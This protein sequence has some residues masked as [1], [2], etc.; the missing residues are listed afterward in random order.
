M[1]N[2]PLEYSYLIINILA[3][4]IPLVLSFDKK[5]AFFK[6]W[7]HLWSAILIPAIL[8]IV[9]DIFFT[10]KGVW[11]FNKTYLT[12]INVANLPLEEVLFFFT[13]PYACVFTYE[14]I[15]VYFPEYVPPNKL[16]RYGTII[17]IL[18]LVVAVLLNP[19]RIYTDITFLLLA[20]ML[21]FLLLKKEYYVFR[22]FYPAY[23]II[24]FPFLFVNGA[25]TGSGFAEPIVWYNNTENL[26]M[27][28]ATIPV[29][30][31]FYGMLLIISNVYIF[32]RNQRSIK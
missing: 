20:G 4:F 17:I 18:A 7:K 24:L 9:W 26:G 32:E 30:D 27:R 28:I 19:W 29:E 8:F 22:H 10:A 16:I 12:G 1:S 14:V 11:G 5:V 13:I 6:K 23:A 21:I 15:K 3:V 25:L 31:I 2:I